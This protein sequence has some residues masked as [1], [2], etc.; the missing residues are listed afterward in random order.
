MIPQTHPRCFFPNCS[1]PAPAYADILK[2]PLPDADRTVFGR[3]RVDQGHTSPTSSA[4]GG[5]DDGLSVPMDYQP[6]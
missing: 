5:G 2:D 4:L 6:A 1:E 3:G